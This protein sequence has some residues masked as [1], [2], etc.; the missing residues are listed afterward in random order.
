MLFLLCCVSFF[1]FQVCLGIWYI[2]IEN[3]KKKNVI[4]LSIGCKFE[5]IKEYS[6]IS[7]N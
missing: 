4:V 2:N 6:G 5:N 7:R 1:Q 3:F